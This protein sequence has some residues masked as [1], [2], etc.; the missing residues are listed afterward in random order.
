MTLHFSPALLFQDICSL[1]DVT[2][3]EDAVILNPEFDQLVKKFQIPNLSNEI[4]TKITSYLYEKKTLQEALSDE[5]VEF[6]YSQ[7]IIDLIPQCPT[8]P[9]EIV[10]FLSVR[11]L[12]MLIPWLTKINA[13]TEEHFINHFLKSFIYTLKS[14]YREIV[15]E[16]YQTI[17][18]VIC[19]IPTFYKFNSCIRELHQYLLVNPSI[20]FLCFILGK[21]TSAH[22][23]LTDPFFAQALES[24]A[25]LSHEF[26]EVFAEGSTELLLLLT[27]YLASLESPALSFFGKMIVFVQDD[28]LDAVIS[29]MCENFIEKIDSINPIR[30]NRAHEEINLDMESQTPAFTFENV[31]DITLDFNSIPSLP[32]PKSYVKICG[33]ECSELITYLSNAFKD[34]MK[35]A[36]FFINTCCDIIAKNVNKESFLSEW[37]SIAEFISKLNLNAKLSITK[38]LM[39]P[40]LFYE[41]LT[42]FNYSD[43]E[44][45][46]DLS[47]SGPQS[48]KKEEQTDE[49]VANNISLSDLETSNESKSQEHVSSSSS[50]FLRP[51]SNKKEEFIVINS[52]REKAVDILLDEK[53]N[54]IIEGSLIQASKSPYV[55]SE[56]CLRMI[57]RASK[58]IQKVLQIPSLLTTIV[59]IS[60]IFQKTYFKQ[61]NECF[62]IARRC[63]LFLLSYLLQSSD[64][65][66]LFYKNETIVNSFLSYMFESNDVLEFIIQNL[67]DY[68]LNQTN[69]NLVVLVD[70]IVEI[71]NSALSQNEKYFNKT[72]VL[73]TNILDMLNDICSFN[74]DIKQILTDICPLIWPIYYYIQNTDECRKYVL[75]SLT[76]SAHMTI[77]YLINEDQSNFILNAVKKIQTPDFLQNLMFPLNE[78]LAGE[79][80]CSKTNSFIIK[81]QHLTKL[82]L[83]LYFDTEYLPQ[84]IDDFIQVCNYSATNI[85]ILSSCGFDIVLLECLEKNKRTKDID[86]TIVSKIL[87]LYSMLSVANSS[88][89]SI[90]RFIKLFSPVEEDNLVSPYQNQFLHTFSCMIEDSLNHQIKFVPLNGTENLSEEMNDER[91]KNGFTFTCWIYIEK[92]KADYRP[93]L[94][95][96]LFENSTTVGVVVTNNFIVPQVITP[97]TQ[98]QCKV[99]YVLPIHKWVFVSFSFKSY[100]NRISVLAT[101]DCLECDPVLLPN[102]QFSSNFK[103]RIG[104]DYSNDVVSPNKMTAPLLSIY[105]NPRDCA[106]FRNLGMKFDE[107]SLTSDNLFYFKDIKGTIDFIP[108]FMH[109]LIDKSVIPAL[110]PL[111]LHRDWQLISDH[112]TVRSF[113]ICIRMLNSILKFSQLAQMQFLEANGFEI[114]SSILIQQWSN[115]FTLRIYQQFEQMMYTDNILIQN[116]VFRNIL[117]NFDLIALLDQK[118]QLKII[119]QCLTDLF[120]SFTEQFIMYFNYAHILH[121]LRIYYYYEVKEDIVQ[122]RNNENIDVKLLR[123]NIIVLMMNF[124]QENFDEDFYTEIIGNILTIPDFQQNIDLFEFLLE[125]VNSGFCKFSFENNIIQGKLFTIFNLKNATYDCYIIK[126]LASLKSKY[127]LKPDF[128]E[129]ITRLLINCFLPDTDPKPLIETCITIVKDIPEFFPLCCFL[130]KK[131]G[132]YFAV[133]IMSLIRPEIIDKLTK[134]A[135]M[136]PLTLC[137]KLQNIDLTKKFIQCLCKCKDKLLEIFNLF[138]IVC[139]SYTEQSYTMKSMFIQTLG[140]IL[141]NKQL[142]ASKHI[143]DVFFNIVKTFLFYRPK[144]ET[145]KYLES[146]FFETYGEKYKKEKITEEPTLRVTLRFNEQGEWLDLDVARTCLDVYLEFNSTQYLPL[147]LILC[148]YMQRLPKSKSAIMDLAKMS[149]TEKERTQNQVYIDFFA[150]HTEIAKKNKFFLH[151]KIPQNPNFLNEFYEKNLKEENNPIQENNIRSLIQSESIETLSM[152]EGVYSV[153]ST[154]IQNKVNENTKL[155]QKQIQRAK[156][157]NNMKW[158]KLWSA[159]SQS[160]GIWC[161][162][163]KSSQTSHCKYR[164]TVSQSFSYIPTKIIEFRF[165]LFNPDYSYEGE[166]KPLITSYPC[167]VITPEEVI[168]ASFEINE[169]EIIIQTSSFSSLIIPINELKCLFTSHGKRKNSGLQIIRTN[170]ESFALDFTGI[171]SI[172]IINKIQSLHPKKIEHIELGTIKDLLEMES[173]DQMWIKGNISTF[174]Y[175]SI[176]NRCDGRSFENLDNYPV[177]PMLY[178]ID[179]YKKD[180]E[181]SEKADKKDTL[182]R[183]FTNA[184]PIPDKEKVLS[185]LS[186]IEPYSQL[187]KELKKTDDNDKKVCEWI[188]EFFCCPIFFEPLFGG[189]KRKAQEFVY[190]NRKLLE[191]EEVS[192]SIHLWMNEVWKFSPPHPQR[193]IVDRKRRSLHFNVPFND[194]ISIYYSKSHFTLL[195]NNGEFLCFQ[196]NFFTI[197]Q[198][199]TVGSDPSSNIFLFKSNLDA[200]ITYPKAIVP[201]DFERVAIIRT[202]K[203]Y[204]DIITNNDK[205]A[206]F[207]NDCNNEYEYEINCVHSDGDWIIVGTENSEIIAFYEQQQKFII[208]TF[209]DPISNVF[210]KEN[211]GLI[212]A[213]TRAGSIIV[214]SLVNGTVLATVQLS[215]TLKP[216]KL[217]ISNCFGF[218]IVYCTEATPIG[219][220]HFISVYSSNLDFVS[221]TEI[222]SPIDSWHTFSTKRAIDYLVIASLSSIQCCEVFYVDRIT[223]VAENLETE[224]I[225]LNYSDEISSIIAVQKNGG[226]YTIPFYEY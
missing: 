190:N 218:V 49:I 115:N 36:Q 76:F 39:H 204:L 89:E 125:V 184:F 219:K 177:F 208:E 188:P 143:I 157:I 144:A 46:D 72:V 206:H 52:L 172:E 34:N 220:R 8:Q 21:I 73:F 2:I 19:L 63:S 133:E 23:K 114:I 90:L 187:Y 207:F 15:E 166:S 18:E 209:K 118:T 186:N 80:L 140:E 138:D 17:F 194:L 47:F 6:P 5:N 65:R 103:I 123:Q 22:L 111:L 131:T 164:H 70:K 221:L 181:S 226:I 216:Q 112:S 25:L 108:K 24:I 171:N 51:I 149:L 224:T 98:T 91:I 75:S 193:S 56:L 62:S 50:Y 120:S 126:I 87:N 165:S 139:G 83:L 142:T 215:N 192:K 86:S 88:H 197:P 82:F 117:V 128:Y 148:S 137:V 85:D 203:P 3:S 141:I 14:S 222:N 26:P 42:I 81:T 223:K 210:V 59:D 84:I 92:Q 69:E 202:Q 16:C 185:L 37:F 135:L 121:I 20:D 158:E 124:A 160:G 196:I 107:S 150:Y 77:Y 178:D 151:S 122:K 53:D 176:L 154:P 43:G 145:N 4:I 97:T 201:I 173:L 67:H 7:E 32:Q 129:K 225:Y 35:A 33:S 180:L 146:L 159:L 95:Q 217:L 199:P 134:T 183:D 1:K 182:Q 198:N 110:F 195:H 130:S 106:T 48:P 64:I 66:L 175:I 54:G 152:I 170:G 191:S 162:S 28:S 45:D 12:Y 13:E 167:N 147:V 200:P 174:E 99:N 163:N 93:I 94:F 156:I 213:V 113:E 214:C 71:L 29:L 132:H 27:S 102:A 105:T 136:W 101:V 161:V 119:K 179:Q 109:N 9:I 79:Y 127:E 38:I 155:E 11:I 116:S 10:D 211:L 78:L 60:T 61:D 168:P 40:K 169:E 55:F 44:V 74:N 205:T 96:I 57:N 31:K 100:C 58:L 41:D 104:D 212:A 153:D 30:I 68:M 189:D